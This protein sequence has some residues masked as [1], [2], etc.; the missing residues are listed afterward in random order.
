MPAK[1]EEKLNMLSPHDVLKYQR[2]TREKYTNLPIDELQRI[3][4]GYE[5]RGLPMKLIC[6]N[7]EKIDHDIAKDIIEGRKVEG[8]NLR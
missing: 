8:R 4:D 5:S 1:T 3:V 7:T 6:P 2:E